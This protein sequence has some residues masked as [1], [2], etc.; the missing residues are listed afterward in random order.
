MHPTTWHIKDGTTSGALAWIGRILLRIV[1]EWWPI[2]LKNRFR[3]M[4]LGKN[5][6]Q[7]RV[8]LRKVW[9]TTISLE[10][11]EGDIDISSS[12]WWWFICAIL[13][14]KLLSG[15]SSFPVWW[16]LFHCLLFQ[17][18]QL[19]DMFFKATIFNTQPEK[20]NNRWSHPSMKN[21]RPKPVLIQIQAIEVAFHLPPL[22]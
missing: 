20:K 7:K 13:G 3:F 17:K 12:S 18:S 14:I 19:Q 16:L 21:I 1:V 15:L 10:D 11:Q 2:M 9:H 8:F 5:A 4:V 22:S 6:T